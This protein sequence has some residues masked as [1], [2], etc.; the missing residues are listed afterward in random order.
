MAY[1]PQ[2][3]GQT[4]QMNQEVEQY[5]RHFVNKQ[6][7]DWSTLLPTAKFALNNRVNSSTKKSPFEIVYGFSPQVGLEPRKESKAERAEEST[8]R[9]VS[10]W[11]DTE[12]ALQL[13]KEDMARHYNTKRKPTLDFAVGDKVWLDT[14][15]ISTM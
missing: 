15:N 7:N 10:T 9:I 12:S 13:A 8:E 11:K 3:D 4:E 2:T 1:H 14:S 6:Q 5:L